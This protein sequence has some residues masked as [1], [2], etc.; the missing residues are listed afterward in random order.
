MWQYEGWIL[1]HWI[2]WFLSYLP[3]KD[4]VDAPQFLDLP[5]SITALTGSNVTFACKVFGKPLPKI[6]WKK[7]KKNVKTSKTV[8]INTTENSDTLEV[9]SE[10]QLENVDPLRSEDVY[11]IEASNKG[12]DI[13]HDV[14][15]IG[16]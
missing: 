10:L 7:G 4:R 9:C 3:V 12:G 6:T 14:Q 11:T 13:T 5:E 8:V 15:L 16:K 2:E 1:I